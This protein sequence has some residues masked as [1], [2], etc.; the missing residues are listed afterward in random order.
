MIISARTLPLHDGRWLNT[1]M[2]KKTKRKAKLNSP[3]FAKRVKAAVSTLREFVK[4]KTGALSPE[5][6]TPRELFLTAC[7]AAKISP[8]PHFNGETQPEYAIRLLAFLGLASEIPTSILPQK[9]SRMNDPIRAFYLSKEWLTSRA[10]Y[11]ALKKAGGRCQCCG[12]SPKDGIRLVVD[13][14]KP[15]RRFWELRFEETNLQV[16]CDDCNLGKG[17]WDATDWR[18]SADATMH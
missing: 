5:K 16:L 7:A 4:Q 8:P 2:S 13:H 12:A 9:K 18:P 10:R 11:S 6:L 3:K 15:V 14:I 1:Y 17:S